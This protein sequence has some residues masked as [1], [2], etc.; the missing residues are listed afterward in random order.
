MK[1]TIVGAANRFQSVFYDVYIYAG[2]DEYHIVYI[3][4]IGASHL[5]YMP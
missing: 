5:D 2:Y 4:Y 3:V 1:L